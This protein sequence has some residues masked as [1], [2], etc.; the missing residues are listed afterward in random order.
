M[1]RR[2]GRWGGA[3]RCGRGGR[4]LRGGGRGVGGSSLLE[5]PPPPAGPQPRPGPSLR[6]VLLVRRRRRRGDRL[7]RGQGRADGRWQQ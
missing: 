6:P 1:P 2:L 3:C 4:G 5:S 7:R